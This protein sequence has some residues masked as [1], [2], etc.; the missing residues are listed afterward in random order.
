MSVVDT[1]DVLIG[2]VKDPVI[3]PDDGAPDSG[4]ASV[5]A[6]VGAISKLENS[7]PA[8]DVVPDSEISDL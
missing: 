7:E 5:C 4:F 2:S 8:A 1:K 3:E 6:S